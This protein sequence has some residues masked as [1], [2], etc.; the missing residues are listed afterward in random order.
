MVEISDERLD[1]SYRK[2]SE[3]FKELTP[4]QMKRQRWQMY[5]HAGRYIEG[6]RDHNAKIA[7]DLYLERWM[8][9]GKRHLS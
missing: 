7:W 6:A 2:S 9:E 4:T 1:Y 8:Y 5:L 3:Y